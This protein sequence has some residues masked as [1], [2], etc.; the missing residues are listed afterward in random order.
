MTVSVY[1]PASVV[2]P[3][4]NSQDGGP[5]ISNALRFTRGSGAER[6]GVPGRLPDCRPRCG[7]RIEHCEEGETQT[8]ASTK[9]CTAI[10]E[11]DRAAQH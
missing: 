2:V 9:E 3:F 6:R 5:K 11:G 7:A 4:A 8:V 10:G 1:A